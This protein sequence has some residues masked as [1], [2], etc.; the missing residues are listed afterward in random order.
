MFNDYFHL[1]VK[2]VRLDARPKYNLKT[3]NN[4]SRLTQITKVRFYC[5]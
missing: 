2:L 3:L 4:V 5:G 1:Y